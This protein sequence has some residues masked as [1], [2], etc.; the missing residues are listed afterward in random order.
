M[1]IEIYG[2][3]GGLGYRLMTLVYSDLVFVPLG[4]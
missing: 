3:R 4:D 1:C 2:R